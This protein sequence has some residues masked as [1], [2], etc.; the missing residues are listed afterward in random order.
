MNLSR[1]V[2]VMLPVAAALALAQPAA[3]QTQFEPSARGETTLRLDVGFGFRAVLPSRVTV[4]TGETLRV[5][6]PTLGDNVT[7][8]W[9]KNGRVISGATASALVIDYVVSNDAGTYQCQ[10]SATPTAQP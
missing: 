8:S 3:A 9:T 6:A 2:F 5:I 10:F 4:P 1:F 7:Y